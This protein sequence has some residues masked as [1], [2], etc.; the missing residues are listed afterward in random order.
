MKRNRIVNAW[1]G[2]GMLVIVGGALAVC[3]QPT[4]AE[5][6]G[7][8]QLLQNSTKLERGAEAD[9]RHEEVSKPGRDAEQLRAD[10]TRREDELSRGRAERKEQLNELQRELQEWRGKLKEL[11]AAGKED[12]AAEVNEHVLRLERELEHRKME[13]RAGPEGRDD[14]RPQDDR[15]DQFEREG[16]EP[17]PRGAQTGRPQEMAEMQRRLRHLH[18][19]IENL[20]AAGLHEPAEHLA[21]EAEKM[22][23]HLH[24]APAQPHGQRTRP[25][26]DIGPERSP[27]E[28][29][30]DAMREEIRNLHEAIQDLRRQ[31]NELSRERR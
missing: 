16:P 15:R 13:F 18:A 8:E 12:E 22:R 28:G 4:N 5:V 11:R 3:S 2:H 24:G 31:V 17:R 20:H 23:Q 9:H 6:R 29:V 30:L 25:F 14:R 19:A 21:Q 10:S 27:R 1:V 7:A 26:P